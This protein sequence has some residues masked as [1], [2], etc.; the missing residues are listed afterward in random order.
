MNQIDSLLKLVASPIGLLLAIIG[1]GVFFYLQEKKNIILYLTS[2]CLFFASFGK[3]SDAFMT[4][5]SLWGPLEVVRNMGRPVTLL[6]FILICLMTFTSPHRNEWKI[7]IPTPLW[8]L[9]IVQY[10]ILLK[11]MYYGNMMFAMIYFILYLLLLITFA[12]GL[13]GRIKEWV[14]LDQLA[15]VIAIAGAIFVWVNTFQGAINRS[16]VVFIQGR[17]SGTTGNPNHAAVFLATV[18]PC[19]LYFITKAKNG[20]SK[21]LWTSTAILGFYWLIA[22]GSRTGLCM[23]VVSFLLFFSHKILFLLSRFI[24][25]GFL[26]TIFLMVFPG[27]VEWSEV[28]EYVG[29]DLMSNRIDRSSE[30]GMDTRAKIWQIQL[31]HF[32]NKPIFGSPV[33]GDR[34]IFGENSWLGVAAQFGWSGLLPLLFFGFGVLNILRKLWRIRTKIPIHAGKCNLAFAG[35]TGILVGSFNEAILL[36]N[37]SFPV[38]ALIIYLFIA[39]K[40][41]EFSEQSFS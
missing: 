1:L 3:Y 30:N 18:F 8:G 31:N 36:G 7:K 27:L 14:D 4:A 13:R 5:P 12:K 37:I 9:I 6:L 32:N 15:L 17:F 38:M 26:V 16:A 34:I 19:L 25:F 40:A 28:T 24:G 29:W 10:L 35:L 20:W 33:S 22:S 39:D 41:L 11:T 2:I 21:L 23:G